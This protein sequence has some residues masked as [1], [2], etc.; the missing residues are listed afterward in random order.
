MILSAADQG[1][2]LD[3][4]DSSLSAV[5]RIW[6][7]YW[8]CQISVPSP[9]SD[10]A[11]ADLGGGVGCLRFEFVGGSTVGVTAVSE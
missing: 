8:L 4:L 5:A 11:T 7:R 2:V 10:T 6:K 3:A 1:A 9:G